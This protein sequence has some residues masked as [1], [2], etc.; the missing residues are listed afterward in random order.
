MLEAL[1]CAAAY[2]ADSLET[3]TG[4]D[5]TLG[6]GSAVRIR[7]WAT[8]SCTSR[9]GRRWPRCRSGSGGSCSCA[10]TATRRSRRSPPSSASRRC[11]CPG[12]WPAPSPSCGS[13]CWPE[14]A[15]ARRAAGS[16]RPG[17]RTLRRSPGPRST[18]ASP[19]RAR[20]SGSPGGWAAAAC[21]LA[22]RCGEESQQP[23]WPQVRHSRR[24]TQTVPMARQ[25][26][27]PSVVLGAGSGGSSATCGHSVTRSSSI[28]LT[29]EPTPAPSA[30]PAPV[31]E[32]CRAG[33]CCGRRRRGASGRGRRCSSR[34]WC[35]SRSRPRWPAWPAG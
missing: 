29:R 15:R 31:R 14:P 7:H 27:Q 8:S 13:S 23:T 25:S 22:C 5:R 30:A 2:T 34:R 6:D 12:C 1:D 32:P 28:A 17:Q 35:W 11:T 3:P 24:C 19:R 16:G 20:T 18:S 10:S 21:L 33:R 9:S 4:E 26:S